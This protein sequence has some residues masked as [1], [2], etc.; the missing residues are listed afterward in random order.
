LRALVPSLVWNERL[1]WFS[2]WAMNVGLFAMCVI[3]LLPVAPRKGGGKL[4]GRNA[5]P[6]LELSIHF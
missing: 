1:L 5:P 3:S 4:H 6:Y 2:F